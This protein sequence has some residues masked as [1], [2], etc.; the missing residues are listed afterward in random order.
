MKWLKRSLLL[1]VVLGAVVALVLAFRPQPIQADTARVTLGRFVDTVRED[2]KTRVKRR[3][4]VSA[5]LAG[6]LDRIQLQPGDAVTENA[7]IATIL[8]AEPPLLDARSRRELAARL[9][10]ARAGLLRANTGVEAARAAADYAARELDTTRKLAASGTVAGS[11]LDRVELEE[12]AKS[13]ELEAARYGARVAQHEV[14]AAQAALAAGQGKQAGTELA[15]RAPGSG[16]ILRVYRESAGVVAPGT[17][18]VELA[19]PSALEVVVDVLSTDAVQ[20][21]PGASVEIENWG[22][23]RPL[24]GRVRV[25]E[26]SAFTR[27]S[28]LGVEE[29][30][31]DVVVDILSPHD[32]WVSLG[33]GFRVEARITLFSADR[34]VKVPVSALFRDGHRW[35][36]YVVDGDR[37]RR[38]C[39]EIS[40]RS[41][42][43]A[44]VQKG[45]APGDR[46]VNYPGDT[47]TDG[48]RIQARPPN[49]S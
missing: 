30:R 2:G 4:V 25:V 13:K 43:D 42:S 31:V 22:G 49:D 14:E 40:R 33:D 37:A 32:D 7:V 16:R 35:C 19:D 29:Q 11:E 17:P 21:L 46:V 8:P 23:A 15:I 36:V 26:P 3:Y 18:L 45:L 20:V 5:P 39:I 6:T 12:K 34:A 24:Q 44:V 38:R 10:V 41:S 48:A 9:G 47:I 1:L 27:V 28:A